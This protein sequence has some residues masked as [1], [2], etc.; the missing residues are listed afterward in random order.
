MEKNKILIVDNMNSA[1]M[2]M[3][4]NKFSLIIK[5]GI[6]NDEILRKYNYVDALIIRSIRKIDET[7][8]EKAKFN[9]IATCSKGI[10]HIDV[11]AAKRNK[12]KIINSESG[13]S[14]SAAEH[15]VGMILNILKQI[16]FSDSKVREGN[17]KFYDFRRNELYGKKVGII[18]FG[19]VGSYVGKLLLAFNVKLIVN[20]SDKKVI[21]SNPL[22]TFRDYEYIFSKCDIVSIHIPMSE[23]NR[24]IISEK[25]LS[26][27]KPDA[28]II[29]TSRGEVLDENYLIRILREKKIY[30]AGLDVFKGEP[31]INNKFFSLNN[32]LLTNHIAGKTVESDERIS[33]QVA[34]KILRYFNRYNAGAL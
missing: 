20:D 15:T 6:S 26:I 24:D 8:L 31:E 22:F 19:K 13:N 33:V 28:I 12:I 30:Y 14:I 7:F 10:D 3:L 2:E 29:N 4:K 5:R 18:G 23:E 27:M 1:G 32:I 17:F 25:Y 21:K 9:L 16:N 34:Q 11:E